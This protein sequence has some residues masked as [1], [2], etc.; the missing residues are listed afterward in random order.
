MA[1]PNDRAVTFHKFHP[2]VHPALEPGL[3]FGTGNALILDPHGRVIT[4]SRALGDDVVIA[5][6]DPAPLAHNLGRSH[7][8][9][10]RPSCTSRS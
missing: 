1:H 4:E 10:R 3:K 8:Q 9:T 5:D 7:L 2:F 6:L